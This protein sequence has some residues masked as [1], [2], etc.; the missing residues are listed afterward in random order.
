[1]G[2]L[3]LWVVLL[4]SGALLAWA[5]LDDW[6][7]FD[8]LYL[9]FCGLTLG[10]F[11]IVFLVMDR[12]QRALAMVSRLSVEIRK[13]ESE[14]VPLNDLVAR[15]REVQLGAARTSYETAFQH[16]LARQWNQATA[17]AKRGLENIRHF[18]MLRVPVRKKL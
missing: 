4:L 10:A 12:S 3:F 2:R 17:E 7:V 8:Q 13:L 6:T 16:L 11:S 18:R 9:S 15:S 1:M 14:P 5:N